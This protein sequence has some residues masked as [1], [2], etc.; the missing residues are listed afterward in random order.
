MNMNSHVKDHNKR[1]LIADK[2]A[3][4]E[5]YLKIMKS[6]LFG[7]KEQTGYE[8]SDFAKEGKNIKLL[9]E[10]SIQL[11]GDIAEA[12]PLCERMLRHYLYLI[13]HGPEFWQ[14]QPFTP[15]NLISKGI[16]DRVL[17]SMSKK[18]QK[19]TITEEQK[20]LLDRISFR[21]IGLHEC[22]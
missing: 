5:L 3:V 7:H 17:Q 14:S 12:E 2:S 22:I 9:I 16:W 18:Q 8:F 20:N 1:T 21:G 19:S 6:F 4:N 13:R 15:S 10:R 11:A